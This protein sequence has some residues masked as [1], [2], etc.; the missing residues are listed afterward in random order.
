M[1]PG[2]WI[3]GI[4]VLDAPAKGRDGTATYR[5]EVSLA[6]EI[7]SFVVSQSKV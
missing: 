5:I 6:G 3:G 1:L 2:E 4:V 7:H